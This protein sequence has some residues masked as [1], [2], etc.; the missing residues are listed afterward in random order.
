MTQEQINK[1]ADE[2]ATTKI[3]N[4]GMA[5]WL[6][7]RYNAFKAGV[8]FALQNQWISV[9]EGLPPIDEQTSSLSIDVFV[10]DENGIYTAA[11]YS[12]SAHTWHLCNGSDYDDEDVI[13]DKITH[14]MKIP[15]LQPSE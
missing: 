5:L 8:V 12:Y 11:W 1:A 14:W 9:D 2:Y 4:T 10:R 6:D 7:I 13:K 15:T 3:G